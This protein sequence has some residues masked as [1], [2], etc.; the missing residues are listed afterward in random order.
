M[1]NNN[2]V[3][4][5][6]ENAAIAA[7][8]QLLVNSVRASSV[9]TPV[10]ATILPAYGTFL[11]RRCYAVRCA[12]SR[13]GFENPTVNERPTRRAGFTAVSGGRLVGHAEPYAS[14]WHA[15]RSLGLKVGASIHHELKS[16]LRADRDIGAVLFSA[17][18]L[19]VRRR[20]T[21]LEHRGAAPKPETLLAVLTSQSTS[22]TRLRL[23]ESELRE[24]RNPQSKSW[25][26]E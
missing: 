25:T 26:S 9:L 18:S 3:F 2:V 4:T 10:G 16:V 11:W 6:A 21:E 17:C 19:V 13:V 12:R 22:S 8:V 15:W 7:E 20:A 24:R 23:A 1:C 5:A 14:D